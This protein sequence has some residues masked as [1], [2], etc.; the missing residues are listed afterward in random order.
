MKKKGVKNILKDGRINPKVEDVLDL[1][2]R[3]VFLSSLFLFPGAAIGIGTIYKIYE[4][5]R[6]SKEYHEWNRYNRPKLSF[7]LHRLQKQKYIRIIKHGKYG[8]LNLTEKGKF[9]L[10][11][12]K[13]DKLAIKKQEKWDG[14]WRIIIYDISK[15]KR[16]QQDSFRRFIK[17]LNMIQLQKSVYITPYPCKKE[18]DT[19]RQYFDIS[20][21]VMY[22]KVEYIEDNDQLRKTF[23]I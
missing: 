1:L 6:E 10:F 14:K 7:T 5:Y 23:K 8:S 4:K 12:Y 11:N 3:G 13:L 9:R 21:E 20:N 18:I 22:M 17:K 15:F 19:L 16:Y 2:L